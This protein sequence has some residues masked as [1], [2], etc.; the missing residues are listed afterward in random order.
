MHFTNLHGRFYSI[1]TF[2]T[3][4]WPNEEVTEAFLIEEVAKSAVFQLGP[5]GLHVQNWLTGKENGV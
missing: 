1:F 5:S 2:E 3:Y 4:C